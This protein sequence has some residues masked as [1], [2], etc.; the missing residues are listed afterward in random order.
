MP[1]RLL[2]LA[3]L[4]GLA[5]LALAS[6]S[7]GAAPSSKE[8][9]AERSPSF[10]Y[11]MK[12]D[13]ILK[14]TGEPISFD[15]V[16]ACGGTV[17]GNAGTEPTVF[18]EHHPQIMFE[19]V[20]DRHVLGLVT[21]DMCESW[22]WEPISSRD[23]EGESRIPDD[24]RPLAIWFE[25]IN[26]LSFGWGYKTD[27]AYDSP[28]AKIEFVE[29]SVTKSDEADWRAWREE[30]EK[31]YIPQG[32]LPG[33]WGYNF[34]DDPLDVQY[35]VSNR[36]E[37]YGIAGPSCFAQTR[38]PM[39]P[40]TIDTILDQTG[41]SEGRFYI[42]WDE[43][44]NIIG[45]LSKAYAQSHDGASFRAFRNSGAR[46]LGTITKS[47]G[48]HVQPAGSRRNSGFQYADVYP[49][50]PRSRFMGD[51]EV[52]QETYAR[53]VLLDDN[54]KGFAACYSYQRPIDTLVKV[55]PLTTGADAQAFDPDAASKTH[56][57]YVGDEVAG[58]DP[59]WRS[60]QQNFVVDR[61]G[62]VFLPT[63]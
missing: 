22:K 24:L 12:A 31:D 59:L 11:R 14:D 47:G 15:Y 20:G 23:R 41:V 43:R 33:P 5:G 36:G 56:I 21:I 42:S 13:F 52:P 19:P 8:Q 44:P 29:A 62:Y 54:Y 30:A 26:D 9:T 40:E 2:R 57:Y 1:I 58:S 39:D 50:L 35:E 7:P 46:Y 60:P 37:G 32:A 63:T 4:L 55:H 28:L 17:L 53:G 38:I 51:V 25:N 16:V 48:G 3:G 49:L 6:C 61:N 18:Y 45:E 27:D 34:S 10:F